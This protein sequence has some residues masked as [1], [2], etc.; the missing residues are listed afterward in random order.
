MR[1]ACYYTGKPVRRIEIEIS[2]S[3]WFCVE[4]HYLSEGME[5][6]MNSGM[7]RWMP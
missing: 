1:P 5:L 2:E 6:C 7:G 4:E 3:G